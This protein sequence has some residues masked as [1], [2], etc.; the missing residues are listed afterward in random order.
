M[1]K[2]RDDDRQAESRRILEGV[3]RERDIGSSHAAPGRRAHDHF[4]ARD[5]NQS[6]WPELW[7]TRIARVLALAFALYLVVWLLSYLSR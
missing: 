2:Q 5:A 6:D 7:G 4:A 1:A 3:N